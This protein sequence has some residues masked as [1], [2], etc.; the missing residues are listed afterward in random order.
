MFYNSISAMFYNS[1]P[2]VLYI[3]CILYAFR[4]II[5]CIITCSIFSL[6][7]GA[8]LGLAYNPAVTLVGLHFEK[9]RSLAMGMAATGIAAGSVVFPPVI[10]YLDHVYA[11]KGAILVTAG[12][13]LHIMVFASVY[14]PAPKR[15]STR[16]DAKSGTNTEG[17]FDEGA[18]VK[19]IRK[20]TRHIQLNFFVFRNIGFVLFLVNNCLY[21]LGLSV[22]IIHMG[23]YA[24]HLGFSQDQAAMLYFA[25]GVASAVGR[26][27]FGLL[28]QIP[29]LGSIKLLTLALFVGGIVSIFFPF[30]KDYQMLVVCASLYG[31]FVASVGTLPPL[32]IVE[33]LGLNLLPSAF[34]YVCM[35]NA[36]GYLIGGPSAGTLWQPGTRKASQFK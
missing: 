16:G 8:G 11:W 25:A 34:G 19:V 35:A 20:A 23:S 6:H 13:V 10:R 2:Y 3:P 21:C 31:F 14:R 1:L 28:A 27:L 7:T 30:A 22:M 32:I 4:I 5:V 17:T 24:V 15:Q 29:A 18:P 26:V 33:L 9:R 36:V 12:L